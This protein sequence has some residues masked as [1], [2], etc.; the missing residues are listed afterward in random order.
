M[1]SI[2]LSTL[3]EIQNW[4]SLQQLKANKLFIAKYDFVSKRKKIWSLFKS[5]K[6]REKRIFIDLRKYLNNDAFELH[7]ILS[8][9]FGQINAISRQ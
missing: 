2:R 5:R 1:H 7:V 9:F 6:Y 8:A 3:E 4:T